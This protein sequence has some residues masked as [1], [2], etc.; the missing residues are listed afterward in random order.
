MSYGPDCVRESMW[1]DVFWGGLTGALTFGVVMAL[2]FY[3]QK[4]DEEL[5]IEV[6]ECGYMGLFA[7]CVFMGG[8]IFCLEQGNYV[9]MVTGI[10]MLAYLTLCSITDRYMQQVYDNVQLYAGILLAALAFCREIPPGV[11]AELIVFGI[12][13]GFLFRRMYGEGDVMGFLICALS[14]VEKGILIWMVHMAITYILLGI[15]QGRKKNVGRDGNL[16]VPVP[17]F[18]YMACAYIFV[19]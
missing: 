5:R 7:L 16:R 12:V 11:G 3:L 17:L 8:G 10:L 1:Q 15:V 2:L 13:Q 14:L 9:R 6:S 4:R 18:P 19:F